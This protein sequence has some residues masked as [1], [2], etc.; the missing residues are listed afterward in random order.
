MATSEIRVLELLRAGDLVEAARLSAQAIGGG[1]IHPLFF[2]ARGAWL[3]RCG[4]FE[5][6]LAD[7]AR[8]GELAPANPG[9]PVSM[10]RCLMP[11][12]RFDEAM[13]CCDRAIAMAPRM[14]AAHFEKGC[15][16]E[17]LGD[18]NLARRC[19]QKAVAL[20][21]RYAPPL[22]RLAALAARHG[23]NAQAHALARKALA[24]APDNETALIAEAEADFGDGHLQGLAGKLDD[25]AGRADL[26]A[27]TRAHALSLKGDVLDAQDETKAA[28]EAYRAANHTLLA[29]HQPRFAGI[30][31]GP[32][33]M[34][35]LMQEFGTI[36]AGR[37]QEHRPGPAVCAGHVFVLGFYRTGTTL[38]GQILAAHPAVTT[39]EE[40]PLLIDAATE[41]L[42]RPGGL[43]R[44]AELSE[45]EADRFRE[46]YWQRARKSEPAIAGKCVVDKQPMNSV[47]LPVIAR[48]FPDAGIL[49]AVRDPRDVVFSCFRRLL[50]VNPATIEMLSLE[51]GAAFYASVM[52]LA[53]RYRRVLPL[54]ILDVPNEAIS[55]DFEGEVRRICGFLGL[56]WKDSLATF[57]QQSKSRSIATPSARQVARG[58]NRAGIGQW[59]RYREQMACVLPVLE[60]WVRRFGYDAD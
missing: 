19:H 45:A 26:D 29:A 7:F 54:R 27:N 31:P 21:P 46:L 34:A 8:A 22:A 15:A 30:A 17:F 50:E 13:A 6:A 43:T 58:I 52:D 60:P 33:R 38:L 5:A 16:A 47:V 23:D 57:A 36:A 28:F 44:L 18:L 4:Q 53:A 49:F 51:R 1:A 59:R 48:L 20:E 56:G 3:Q 35:A 14:A 32:E 39:L 9:A 10:A 55:A 41:F 11:L 12:G 37:W 42:E 2:D 25:V 24:I 40:K